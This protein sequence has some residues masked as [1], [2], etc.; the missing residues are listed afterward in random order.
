MANII[1][2]HHFQCGKYMR[3]SQQGECNEA[4]WTL[5]TDHITFSVC[6][7]FEIAYKCS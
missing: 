2:N 7:G 6:Y 4:K 3:L 5:Q 1:K